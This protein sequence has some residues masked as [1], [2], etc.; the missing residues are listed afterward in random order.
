MLP[1]TAYASSFDSQQVGQDMETDY[2]FR[3][4]ILLQAKANESATSNGLYTALM[5]TDGVKGAKIVQN[6]SPNKDS[7]GNPPY[8]IHF[9]VAGGTD[10]DVA[11][12][13][14]PQRCNL[15]RVH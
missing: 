10:S 5:N 13:I 15:L 1:T 4:R 7:Y 11:N 12:T 2:D 3:N 6:V 9:Y 14:W 8:T